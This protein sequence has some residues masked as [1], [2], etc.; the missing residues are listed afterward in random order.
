MALT[1]ISSWGGSQDN[2][3]A[4]L[5]EA[6]EYIGNSTVIG[7]KLDPT[8]WTSATSVQKG[9][10]LLAATRDVDGHNFTGTRQF[11]DQT[12]EFPRIPDGEDSWPWVNR[13]L[14]DANTYNIY[15]TEQKRRVKAAV[16]EQA[17]SY[18]RDGERNEHIERQLWGIRSFSEGI[19]PISESA[20]YGGITMTLVPEAM[21]LLMPYRGGGPTLVR[22]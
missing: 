15:L 4:T 5:D 17:F 16:I 10:C 20:S 7:H 9:T 11:H 14:T 12:L 19:G 18:M 3:Y 1:L 8:P 13:A 2:C 21:R 22:S 6:D